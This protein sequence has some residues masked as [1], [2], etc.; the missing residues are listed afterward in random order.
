MSFADFDYT[1][2]VDRL[3]AQVNN[4]NTQLTDLDAKIA[5]C[6]A[7][8]STY[9]TLVGPECATMHARKTFVTKNVTDWNAVLTEITRIQALSTEDKASL[10]AIYAALGED[11]KT[12][13]ARMLFNTTGLLADCSAILADGT[14]TSDQKTMLLKI[15]MQKYNININSRIV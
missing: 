11:L 1:K 4:A 6:D 2:T 7:L 12:W 14:L 13:M 9:S 8:T 10:Y 15:V 3:T 5:A